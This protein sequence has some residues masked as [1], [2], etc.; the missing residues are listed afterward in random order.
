MLQSKSLS[1]VV[2]L[3][4]VCCSAIISLAQSQAAEQPNVLLIAIDDLNDW[5]GCLAGHPNAKTPHIDA[6]AKRGTLFT[7]AHCQAP[8][9]GP[10]RASLL[11]GRFPHTTGIYQQPKKN[12]MADDTEFFAGKLLPEYFAKHGYR[13]VGGGKITHGYPMQKAFQVAAPEFGGSGPKPGDDTTRFNYS[14]DLSI[15]FSGTQT[16]WAAFPDVDEKMPDHKAADWAAQELRSIKGDKPFFLAVGF[17]RPHVPFYVPQKWFDMFPLAEI[18]LP[19]IS[20]DDLQDVPERAAS[21][22]AARLAA[23]ERRRAVAKMR[24]GLLSVYGLC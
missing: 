2:A 22:P 4:V 6:L 8:I 21:I 15:P 16:D 5:V 11:S 1:R 23:Q 18:A 7:N 24:A 9:C 12:R 3:A 10:S 19:E 14:P 20:A 13:T 17:V